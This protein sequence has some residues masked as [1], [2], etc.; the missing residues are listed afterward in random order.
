ME[1]RKERV[2]GRKRGRG[3][4]VRGTEKENG[5]GEREEADG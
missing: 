3:G 5:G 2:V 4:R 1:E